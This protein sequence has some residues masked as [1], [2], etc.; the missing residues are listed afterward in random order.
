M[1]R[2]E[3]ITLLGGAAAAWPLTGHAQQQAMPVIGFLHPTSPDAF[4]DRLRGFR[5]GLRETGYVEGENVTITYRFAENQTDRLPTMAAELVNSRVAVIAAANSPS[6]LAA[7]VATT[8]IPVVFISPEDPVRLGLVTSLAKPGGNL[9]GINLLSG[10]LVAKRLELLHELVP[11]AARVAVLVNPANATTTETTLRDVEVAA[12]TIGL[13]IQLL[14]ASTGHEIDEA[15]PILARERSNALFVSNDP[16][17]TSRRVQLAILAAHHAIPSTYG[18]REIAEVGGLMS[19]GANIPHGWR[20][21]GV[22]VG[23]ILRGAKP[24]ELPVVQSTKLELVI[25][26]QT[27]RTISLAVPPTLLATA[28][29]VIE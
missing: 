9:S 14:K 28:D 21:A 13:Q 24:A 16:F 25:N 27:A 1:R 19:Y 23:L 22:Y 17:F 6:A 3:F 11:G 5:Q 2:R 12:R 20:Q 10:E 4:P 26:A 8:T 15:F 18:T 29:E 7:K